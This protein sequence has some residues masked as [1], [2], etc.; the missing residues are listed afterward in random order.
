M[1][2][3]PVVS[4]ETELLVSI[5]GAPTY[6]Y[7]QGAFVWHD[8]VTPDITASQKFYGELFG[9]TFA[10]QGRYTVILND[11]LRIGGMLELLPKEGRKVEA[12]WLAYLSVPDVDLASAY[13]KAKGGQIL[14][15]PLDMQNR[16]RGALVS[17][18]QGAQ[19]LLLHALGGDPVEMKPV[20]GGWLWD[21]LWSNQAQESFI[22]Y[23]SLGRYDYRFGQR[24]YLILE[25]QGKWRAGIRHIDEIDFQVRWIP[26]VR[27]ADPATLLD[28]VE[29]LGGKVWIRP[30]DAQQDSDANIAVISD[31]TGA[32]LI[33]QRWSDTRGPR[34]Q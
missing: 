32:L 8:L 2:D 5:T 4:V 20:M 21:E 22:F 19:F 7:H 29:R 6:S 14:K 23:Q 17:D 31:N 13:V 24:E 9:W 25:N 18:P 28:K 15:G 30:G 10:Q 3:L 27:V 34:E 16:G 11:K 26:A 33:L 1:Q 12:L